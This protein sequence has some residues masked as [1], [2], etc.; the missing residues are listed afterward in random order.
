MPPDSYNL[1]LAPLRGVTV[2][3]FR[4]C[5]ARHFRAPDRAIAPFIPSFSGTRI[6]PSLLGDIDPQLPQ[7]IPLTPQALSK[8]PEQLRV[9][10]HAFQDF[11]YATADL[12]AGCPW[13]FITKKGRGSALLANEALLGRLLEVGCAEYPTGFSVKVRLGLKA[14]DLLLKRMPLLNSFPLRE[15][16]IHARTAAQM[17]DGHVNLDAFEAAARVSTHPIVYNGDIFTAED[18]ATLRSRFPFVTRWMIGRGLA[19]NPFLIE[20]IRGTAASAKPRAKRLID[21][22]ADYLDTC[23]GELCG[24]GPVL[25]RM[26]ELWGHLRMG[27]PGSERFWNAV[28]ICRTADEYR[29]VL[30]L[31]SKEIRI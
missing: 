17:Y 21:F 25:G 28:K 12:N 7:P 19:Q 9:A 11:G 24:P 5:L 27:L 1:C 20:D 18:F 22:L 3:S 4:V 16:T 15:V 31:I 29:R 26:K 6:K 30:N 2:R 14:P 8:D 13:P 10:L 23:L